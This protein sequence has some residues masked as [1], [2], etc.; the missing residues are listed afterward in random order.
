MTSMI[1][2]AR[3]D[4]GEAE[5]KAVDRVLRSGWLTSG[6]EV[7]AFEREFAEFVGARHA[8]ALHSCTAALHLSLLA[9]GLGPE[10]AVLVPAITF[11][12]TAEAVLYCQALPV[13]CDV[14]PESLL[15]SP[16]GVRAWIE[17]D[18]EIRD[19]RLFHKKSGRR[20]RAL[21]PVH[22]G[23]RPCDLWGLRQICDEWGL[24]LLDDAAHALGSSIE[25]NH[26][27]GDGLPQKMSSFSF[28]ATK[29]ITTGEGGM[30]TLRDDA[31]AE[32]I[33]YK[34]LHGIRG[35]SYGRARWDYDVVLQGYKYNMTDMAA[36]IG[37][38]QLRR[39]AAMQARRQEISLR[40]HE[41]LACA[42]SVFRLPDLVEGSSFH[43][44]I[45]QF[46]RDD[47][48]DPFVDFMHEQG[49][50]VSLHFIPLY[51]HSLWKERFFETPD[52]FPASEEA[53][54]RMVSLP[55]YS[56]LGDAE[57]TRIVENIL[58]FSC[59]AA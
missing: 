40:Y 16:E 19:G 6:P 45:I 28:Y 38:V 11:I 3:P 5:R 41:E 31:L 53:F 20:I 27:G 7:E 17:R 30:L 9:S 55:I 39:A 50:G 42:S 49:I 15:L 4:I 26:I 36:A 58:K 23:G 43:L 48:R 37:R 8:I 12:A 56:A 33:R 1:P 35:Q 59:R 54:R 18:A 13:L 10:D 34:R 29:N 32:R 46:Q 44:F 51:R 2:F 14:D 22:I 57:I 25:G 52:Q 24:D 47:L 21:L